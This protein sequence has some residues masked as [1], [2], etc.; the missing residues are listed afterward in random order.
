M[1]GLIQ[2]QLSVEKILFEVTS[3]FSTTGLTMGITMSLEWSSKI[4]LCLLMFFGRVGPL[5]IIGVVNRNWMTES[6]E[7]VQYVEERVIVG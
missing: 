6:K 3:A 5:T 7:A 2:P 1:I 4:I